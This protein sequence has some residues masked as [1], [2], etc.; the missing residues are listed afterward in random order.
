MAPTPGV[1]RENISTGTRAGVRDDARDTLAAGRSHASAT[2][3]AHH[4]RQGGMPAPHMLPS[5]MGARPATADLP[6]GIHDLLLDGTTATSRLN[7]SC[8]VHRHFFRPPDI[9]LR[10]ALSSASALSSDSSLRPAY[11][12]RVRRSRR[13]ARATLTSSRLHSLDP[14]WGLCGQTAVTDVTSGAH[15]SAVTGRLGS[16]G[17]T[18]RGMR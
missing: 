1:V 7:L 4:Q 6:G 13:S 14:D 15:R 9:S 18:G 10:S 5:A 8:S 17:R 2:R 12:P 3:L 11:S 16:G